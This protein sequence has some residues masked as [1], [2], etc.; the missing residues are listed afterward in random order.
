MEL[1]LDRDVHAG[2]E[3]ELLELVHGFGRR[4]DDVEQAFVGAL[5]EGFLRFF[6]AMRRALNGEPL[7]ASWKGNWTSDARAGAFDG[8]RD[9][10]G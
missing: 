7:D 8:I 9:I 1:N 10:A 2:G 5:F 4:L 6:I 3:I